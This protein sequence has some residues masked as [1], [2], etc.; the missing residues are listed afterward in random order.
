MVCLPRCSEVMYAEDNVVTVNPKVLSKM[1]SGAGI[2][3]VTIVDNGSNAFDSCESHQFD[4]MQ[5]T[6]KL[7]VDRHPDAKVIF[8]TAHGWKNSRT[9]LE[10]WVR[11]KTTTCH[12]Y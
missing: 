3:D 9:R 12:G 11:L 10:R 8:E 2:D 4:V 1:L 6:T 5:A 7:I